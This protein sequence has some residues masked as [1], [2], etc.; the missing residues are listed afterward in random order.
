MATMND[1]FPSKYL[2]HEDLK[3]NDA[4]VTIDRVDLE[5]VGDDQRPKPVCYFRDRQKG[6]I[7]NKT[8][9]GMIARLHGS[10]SDT[11]NGKVITLYPTV[12]PYQGKLVGCIRVRDQNAGRNSEKTGP[13]GSDDDDDNTPPPPSAD[14]INDEVPW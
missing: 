1:F 7:L 11:W 8:N 3:G 4:V 14:D 10:D 2:T 5:N 9:F 13:V 6:F 12:T